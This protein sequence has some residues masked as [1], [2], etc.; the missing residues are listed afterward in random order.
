MCN[1]YY[2]DWLDVIDFFLLG[3]ILGWDKVLYFVDF[4]Y[5]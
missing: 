3:V 5:W 2:R 4:V 1:S